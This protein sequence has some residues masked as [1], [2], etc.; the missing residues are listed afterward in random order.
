MPPICVA[1]RRAV[2][3]AGIT[4]DALGDRLE[5]KQQTV[6]AWLN[7]RE[8][9]LD[10]LAR[11]EKVLGLTRGHLV[12]AAGYVE[13]PATVRD[14]IAGDVGLTQRW[15]DVV[16]VVYDSSVADSARDRKSDPTA[17]STRTT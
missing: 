13:D 12:R 9:K 3:E 4:Q 14:S 6:S 10:D 16:L 7:K 17:K 5:E 15:R 2:E 8:P 1:L 11:I